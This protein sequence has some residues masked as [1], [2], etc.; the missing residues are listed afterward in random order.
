[1]EAKAYIYA[2]QG[3]FRAKL[4]IL[5][6]NLKHKVK[7]FIVCLE[8]RYSRTRLQKL[9]ELVIEYIR[10]RGDDHHDEDDLL[11]VMLEFK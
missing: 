7:K 5:V 2:V 10:L 8:K 1:M 9:E 4:F 11:Q 3:H 6:P